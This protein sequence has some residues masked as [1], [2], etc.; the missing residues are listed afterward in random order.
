VLSQ[1]AGRA[2][3]DVDCNCVTHV[4]R[5]GWLRRSAKK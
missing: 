4:A 1:G 5:T 3:S 2:H